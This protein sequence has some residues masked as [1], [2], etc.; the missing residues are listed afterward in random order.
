MHTG[1]D[2]GIEGGGG[3]RVKICTRFAQAKI[4]ALVIP[5]LMYFSYT[6]QWAKAPIHLSKVKREAGE[7]I[8]WLHTMGLVK[9]GRSQRG[10]QGVQLNPP[11][12]LMR[13]MTTIVP[14]GKIIF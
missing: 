12:K 6:V 13:F 9:Q 2:P 7:S 8:R 3:R 4:L 10:V 5:T 1:A 11:S 14:C